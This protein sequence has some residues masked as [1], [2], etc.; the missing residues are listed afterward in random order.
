MIREHMIPWPWCC[1]GRE[2]GQR[3]GVSQGRN[4]GIEGDYCRGL[5]S[6]GGKEEENYYCVTSARNYGM[7]FEYYATWSPVV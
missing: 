7:E 1:R 6:E 5:V 3:V 2:E 4:G